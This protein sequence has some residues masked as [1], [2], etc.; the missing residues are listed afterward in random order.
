MRFKKFFFTT[1]LIFFISINTSF[2]QTETPSIS[3]LLKLKIQE[4]EIQ[5]TSLREVISSSLSLRAE[6]LIRQMAEKD[7]E[8]SPTS[9]TSLTSA[10][11]HF[12]KNLS[13]GMSD[14]EVEKLQTLFIEFPEIYPE[15]LVTGFFGNLTQRALVRFQK[16]RGLETIGFVGPKTRMELNNLYEDFR[17]ARK[18]GGLHSERKSS[19]STSASVTTSSISLVEAKIIILNTTSGLINDKTSLGIIREGEKEETQVLEIVNTPSSSSAKIN[20]IFISLSKDKANFNF[21]EPIRISNASSEARNPLIATRNNSIFM[22]WQESLEEKTDIFF[23]RSLDSGKTF[24]P[25]KNISNSLGLPKETA[26]NAYIATGPNGVVAIAWEKTIYKSKDE[27]ENQEIYVVYS[28]NNGGTFSSPK[29]ISN[30]KLIARN[31]IIKINSHGQI[32]LIWIEHPIDYETSWQENGVYLF[33]EIGGPHLM[34]TYSVD[35]GLNYENP[36]RITDDMP[37]NSYNLALDNFGTIHIVMQNDALVP[38]G[39]KLKESIFYIKSSK[40]YE[41]STPKNIDPTNSLSGNPGIITDGFRNVHVVWEN[42]ETSNKNFD[43]FSTRSTNVGGTFE[44]LINISQT[45]NTHSILRSYKQT[46]TIEHP[47]ET[48]YVLYS[49]ISR[50][51]PKEN[52]LYLSRSIDLG[53]TWENKTLITKKEGGWRDTVIAI[54]SG[55]ALILGITSKEKPE[56]R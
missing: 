36:K 28:L 4:L 15:G 45:E 34:A 14:P 2:A 23:T 42:N 8:Q 12:S 44:P 10:P 37:I 31:P 54:T 48:L 41:F 43:V 17:N 9:T 46:V 7:P 38:R 3:D 11:A 53:K 55:E 1:G 21:N 51:Q 47:I 29:N 40:P 13:L 35:N 22:V 52:N 33:G 6:G 26:R 56:L 49:E 5:L 32:T 30:S 25:S 19:S 18:E 27:I 16:T 39:I 20:Q 24:S 50:N